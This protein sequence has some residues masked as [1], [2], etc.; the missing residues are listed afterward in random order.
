[1]TKKLAFSVVALLASQLPLGLAAQTQTVRVQVEN[2]QSE[3]G[4]FLTPLW[5]GFHGGDF[6]LFNVGE[7]AS[8]G[9]ED[10]AEEGLVGGLNNE[11]SAFGSSGAVLA[12]GGFGG[13]PVIDPGETAADVF[14]FDVANRYF[15]YASMVIPSN[16]AFIGNED[17][18][19][20]ELLDEDGNF[21]GPVVID[22][23]GADI[24]DSGTELNDGLGAAFSVVV[25]EST[26]E[27]GDVQLHPGLENFL[28]TETLAGTTIGSIPG[29][30]TPIARITV[31]AIPEP[32]ATTVFV[33]SLA[34]TS[35][36]R[37]K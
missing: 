25:G 8:P 16:D 19:A 1:M 5:V 11:I 36:R 31:T 10:L 28:G 30:A 35:L 17:Q 9:L 29:S 21:I 3:D 7:A 12:P 24:Y 26:D 20:H 34:V 13:A 2:L 37:R 32:A 27:D 22:I 23:F 14:E 15:S 33:I 4:F 18:L 6:D